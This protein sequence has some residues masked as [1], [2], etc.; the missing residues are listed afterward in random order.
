VSGHLAGKYE[1]LT[2]LTNF[3]REWETAGGWEI[4]P[5]GTAT[6]LYNSLAARAEQLNVDS[7]WAFAALTPEQLGLIK[8]IGNGGVA[9]LWRVL[10][11]DAPDLPALSWPDVVRLLKPHEDKVREFLKTL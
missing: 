1:R 4:K 6:R 5:P 10:H 11:P 8:G 7:F 2:P 9:V 3:R